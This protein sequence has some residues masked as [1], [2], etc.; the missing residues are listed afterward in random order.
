MPLFSFKLFSGSDLLI[1][2]DNIQAA[3]LWEMLRVL[4]GDCRE[5]LE[6][7]ELGEE[8]QNAQTYLKGDQ[9][10]NSHVRSEPKQFL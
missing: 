1:E 4:A 3:G 2:Q 7:G 8:P 9:L 5:E 10:E 6:D